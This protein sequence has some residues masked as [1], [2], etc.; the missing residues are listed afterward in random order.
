VVVIERGV[1][2][3]DW[4]VVVVVAVGGVLIVNVR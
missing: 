2:L 3:L 4:V 1:A